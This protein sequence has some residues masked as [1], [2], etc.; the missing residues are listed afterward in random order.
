[1]KRLF[2]LLLLFLTVLLSACQDKYGILEYQQKDIVAKCIINEKYKVEI[3]KENGRSKVV[4]EEPKEA[5]GIT[6]EVGE[7]VFVSSG[8]MK[9]EMERESLGGICALTGIFSQ[10][11][12]YLTVA[13]Q[14]GEESELTF[15]TEKCVYKL[16]IG[17]NGLPKLVSIASE[18]FIY[19]VEILSI[20]LK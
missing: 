5:S 3:S 18:D 17:K 15:Q 2:L 9:I 1:M 7:G 12:D 13:T 19:Q 4:V 16:T 11:E 20:E 6:F 14:K 8:E 10:D